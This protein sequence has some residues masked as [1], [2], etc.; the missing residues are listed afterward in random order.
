[1]HSAVID[2]KETTRIIDKYLQSLMIDQSESLP[3][4]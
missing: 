2:D 4:Q 3:L 1:M